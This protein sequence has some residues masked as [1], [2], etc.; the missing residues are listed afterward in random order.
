MRD[1]LLRVTCDDC[2]DKSVSEPDE[3]WNEFKRDLRESGWKVNATL[4][5]CPACA[6][7][8]AL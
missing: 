7:I 2:D 8:E 3:T 5:L 1:E 4:D 6:T